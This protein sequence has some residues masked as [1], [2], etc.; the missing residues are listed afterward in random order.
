MKSVK[1]HELD[2]ENKMTAISQILSLSNQYN[3]P[4]AT[5]WESE[6]Q[7]L[8]DIENG[9]NPGWHFTFYEDDNTEDVEVKIG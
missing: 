5:T 1:F 7:L 3:Y 4:N 6:Q 9:Y 2:A 8:D